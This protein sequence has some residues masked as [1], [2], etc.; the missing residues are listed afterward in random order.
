M[1]QFNKAS[2]AQAK[3]RC[4]VF[5][6][7]GSGKTFTA[8]RMATGMLAGKEGKIAVVDTERGSAS[9]Y[10]DR[11]AFDVCDLADR[12]ID[13]YVEAFDAAAEA[14]YDVLIIDS[15]SHAWQELLAEVDHLA[16][17]RRFRGNKWAAWSEGTPK[18]RKLVNKLL[19]YP[20]HVFGTIRTK[21]AWEHEK[22]ERTGKTKPVRIGLVPEQGKG[23]EYEFDLL[24]QIDVDHCASV[25]K[26][27]TGKYQDTIFEKPGEDFG[28]E[29]ADWLAE[30]ESPKPRPAGKPAVD[31]AAE[32]MGRQI[33]PPNLDR[34][35][36][37]VREHGL[38]EQQKAAW[39]E[40]FKVERLDQL[41]QEQVDAIVA[42]IESTVAKGD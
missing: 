19:D 40:H 23:I 22:D 38:T 33:G 14:G 28:R 8:L 21:T 41:T 31:Q 35:N 25:L 1:I 3:L 27:R 24:L 32:E 18:Q 17:G 12:T 13:G 15:L 29:L 34:L 11:F 4:A 30:G 2:K 36:E 39:R 5:G 7:S 16:Q 9:K 20:G 10:A 42:K 6:P 26:D 37:L